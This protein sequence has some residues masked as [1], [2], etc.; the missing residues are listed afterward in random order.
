MM[1]ADLAARRRDQV[2]DAEAS[3]RQRRRILEHLAA[4][5]LDL[6]RHRQRIVQRLHG[7]GGRLDDRL[8]IERAL[9]QGAGLL[10][11]LQP[12]R[13]AQRRHLVAIAFQLVARRNAPRREVAAAPGIDRHAEGGEV[14]GD[15]V[16]A[17]LRQAQQ[18]ARRFLARHL[19]DAVIAHG[20]ARRAESAVAPRCAPADAPAFQ[21]H[22]RM[23]T[24]RQLQRDGQAG[25]AATHDHG[26][27]GDGAIEIGTL[28]LVRARAR[29]VAIDVVAHCSG[30]GSPVF[31]RK[32]NP[33]LEPGCRPS[34]CEMKAPASASLAR[35]MP[36]SMPMPCSM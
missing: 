11:A 34:A 25:Q 6:P 5:P 15:V 14:V 30:F 36:V 13:E 3:G 31:A 17:V 8:E 20:I 22:D 18:L 27:G 32:A 19:R 1:R 24:A 35:S 29:V 26:A 21:Q 10:D 16:D 9:Q 7:E 28:S 2:R 33:A 12:Q 4:Q 23:P